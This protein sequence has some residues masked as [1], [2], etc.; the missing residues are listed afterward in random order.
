MNKGLQLPRGMAL[1]LHRPTS[2][3]GF[4]AVSTRSQ[5]LSFMHSQASIGMRKGG[6]IGLDVPTFIFNH[7]L[8]HLHFFFNIFLSPH[9]S[10]P[11]CPYIRFKSLCSEQVYWM[12][13]NLYNHLDDFQSALLFFMTLPQ[14]PHIHLLFPHSSPH[15][16]S[17][18]LDRKH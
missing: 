6:R 8:S 16:L 7:I 15:S 5:T 13:T 9:F 11:S 12:T 18:P 2:L 3:L 4:V 1:L 14:C 10:S 17:L